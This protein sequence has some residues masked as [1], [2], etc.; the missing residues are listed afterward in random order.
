[1]PLHPAEEPVIE[2]AVCQI[3]PKEFQSSANALKGAVLVVDESEIA[4]L[5]P[6]QEPGEGSGEHWNGGI[7]ECVGIVEQI[8]KLFPLTIKSLMECCS[9]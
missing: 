9:K 7:A 8:L 6:G 2:N 4:A 5:L 1:L 3:A